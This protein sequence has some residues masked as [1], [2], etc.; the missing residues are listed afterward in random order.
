MTMIATLTIE[1][2]SEGPAPIIVI[3][4]AKTEDGTLVCNTEGNLNYVEVKFLFASDSIPFKIGDVITT[5][6]G[7]F[8]VQKT[9]T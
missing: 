8:S 7:H 9:T 6:H 2:I 5:L 1:D 4:S 3:A